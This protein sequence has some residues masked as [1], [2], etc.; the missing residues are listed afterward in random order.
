MK[1]LS[2]SG[3]FAIALGLS[4]TIAFAQTGPRLGDAAN[5]KPIPTTTPGYNSGAGSAHV[6]DAIDPG[7]A[8]IH[9][10]EY[11]ISGGSARV[12]GGSNSKP[13]GTTTPGY[14]VG[15]GSSLKNAVGH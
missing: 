3:A 7:L 2:L 14:S 5:T 13:V 8:G 4:T 9:A 6:D 11:N 15:T 1:I 10:P 12:A